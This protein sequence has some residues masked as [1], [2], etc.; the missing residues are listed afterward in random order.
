LWE[1]IRG[2]GAFGRFK[3]VLSTHPHERESWFRFKDEQMRRRVLDWLQ[4]E[5]IQPIS[6]GQG[7][8]S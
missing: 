7:G 3:D 1:A 5:G 8:G 4:E 6:P 2:R